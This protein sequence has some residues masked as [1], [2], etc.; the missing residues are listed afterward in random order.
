MTSFCRGLLQCLAF[1]KSCHFSWDEDPARTMAYDSVD[2]HASYCMANSP[3]LFE[4]LVL[5]KVGKVDGINDELEIAGKGTF[6]FKLTDDDSRTHIICI[7]N[8]LYLPK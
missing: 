3:H 7:P 1:S 4:N 2:N 5:S 8:S 6:K